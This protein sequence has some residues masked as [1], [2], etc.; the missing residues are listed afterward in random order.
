M[1][2]EDN[3]EPRVPGIAGVERRDCGFANTPFDLLPSATDEA[4]LAGWREIG[5]GE[6]HCAGFEAAFDDEELAAIGD[7]ALVPDF[8]GGVVEAE[9]LAFVAVGALVVFV[10]DT[11]FEDAIDDEMRVLVGGADVEG[12]PIAEPE[13][14][15]VV[16][17]SDARRLFRGL[18]MKRGI[19][20]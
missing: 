2:A 5:A 17:G 9:A 13:I 18:W 4:G 14:E 1:G 15:L 6:D 19:N 20:G 3:V 16:F 10:N 11:A 8:F 12:V 7:P